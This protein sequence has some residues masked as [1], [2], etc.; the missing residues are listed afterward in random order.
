MHTVYGEDFYKDDKAMRQVAFA[1]KLDWGYRAPEG[2]TDEDCKAEELSHKDIL[3]NQFDRLARC[4]YLSNDSDHSPFPFLKRFSMIKQA[5][6]QLTVDRLPTC[7]Y[8]IIKII[9]EYPDAPELASVTWE[10][11]DASYESEDFKFGNTPLALGY[12]LHDAM[13]SA[14]GEHSFENWHRWDQIG[15]YLSVPWTYEGDEGSPSNCENA[16]DEDIVD[17][18]KW[19][20]ACRFR[21]NGKVAKD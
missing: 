3:T 21:R 13:R 1:P 20:A 10:M 6:S 12:L 9:R 19:V 7:F 17:Q 5:C 4:I 16:T 18:W 15:F 14:Y 8:H 2:S 11:R